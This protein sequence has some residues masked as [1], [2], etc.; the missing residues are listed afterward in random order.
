MSP[1]QIAREQCSNFNEGACSGLDFDD[2]SRHFR[3][4]KAGL[5]CLLCQRG[6]RCA[7]FETAVLPMD[8]SALKPAPR[9]SWEDGLREYRLACNVVNTANR[10]I[11]PVC[12]DRELEPR[13]RLCYVC[14]DKKRKATYRKANAGSQVQQLSKM[15]A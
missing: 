10:R 6:V 9:Q 7:F 8:R 15:A 2:H 3:F 13:T 14:R 4:R 1:L 5:P 12:K 11:C